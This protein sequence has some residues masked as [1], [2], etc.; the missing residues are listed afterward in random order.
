M[1]F[2]L[3]WSLSQAVITFQAVITLQAGIE[4]ILVWYSTFTFTKL[5]IM[6]A[7]GNQMF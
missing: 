3:S 5:Y 1:M 4:Y 2:Q 6:W 7:V